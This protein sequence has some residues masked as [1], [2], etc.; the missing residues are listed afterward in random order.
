MASDYHHG[1]LRRALLDAA[2]RLVA[3]DGVQSTSLRAVAR[4]AGVSHAAPAHH[5]RD[6]AALLAALA[7]EGHRLL[8][9][10]LAACADLRAAGAAYLAVATELPGHFAV[11]TRSDLADPADHPDLAEAGGRSFAELQRLAR[12]QAGAADPAVVADLAWGLAHGL[13][14]LAST[15][16]LGGS[17]QAGGRAAA[18]M[19][20]LCQRLG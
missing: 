11:M 18:A 1:D 2:A 19:D 4:M 7:A 13:A 17:G 14:T 12:K 10:R 16:G 20:L 6:K 9:E 3:S 5:F 15:G 8:A